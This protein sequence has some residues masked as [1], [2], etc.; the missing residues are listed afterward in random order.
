MLGLLA[1]SAHAAPAAPPSPSGAPAP[2]PAP[3]RVPAQTP[4]PPPKASPTPTPTPTP[5]PKATPKPAPKATIPAKPKP[6]AA[7]GRTTD[8]PARRQISGGPSSE[9]VMLGPDTAELRA[10]HAAERELFPIALPAAGGA[11]LPYPL[12]AT[13]EAPR[14]HATGLPPVPVSGPPPGSEGGRDLS[15]LGKLELPDVPVRWDARL[16]RYLEFFKDDPRGRAMLSVWLRRS[17]RYKDQLKKVLRRK[18]VPE[19]LVWLAMIESGFEPTARSPVGA[20]GIWQFMPDTGRAYGLPQDRWADQRL[21]VTQ[22]TEAAAD[23]LGD[24]HRRFGSW[25]LAIAA[26]NM[27]YGGI[28]SVVRRYNTNDFWTL[29]RLEGALPWETTLYVPKILAAAIVAKNPAVFGFAELVPDAP[30]EADEVSVPAGVALSVV[31]SAA[32]CTVKEVEA[33][34]PELRASRTPPPPP[35]A[36][37]PPPASGTTASPTP[38]ADYAV[39]V[40][41]GKGAACTA[42][43]AKSKKDV[44][45]KYVVRFGETLEQIAKD[46]HVTTQK[47]VELNGVAQNEIVRGGATLLVPKVDPPKPAPGAPAPKTPEAGALAATLAQLP[48]APIPANGALVVT[49]P[50]DVF[51]YPD[52]RR[53][54]YR[55]VGGDTLPQIAGAFHVSVD[56]LRRWNEL[57]PAARLLEGMTLQ[58]FVREDADLSQAVHLESQDVRVVAVGSE[59]FFAYHEGL[60][61]KKRITVAAK[62]GETLEAIGRKHGVSPGM[63]ERINH[64]PRA[65]ALKDG[66]TVA[67]YVAQNGPAGSSSSSGPFVATLPSASNAPLPSGPLPS[68]PLPDLLPRVVP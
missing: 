53:V 57:D 51:V 28:L 23:F 20:L 39:R 61:G 60:K 50:T 5:T 44:L 66:D 42:S 13:S 54:F 58:L 26:Y 1:G 48:S 55:V 36:P 17:G 35:Q 43:L 68:G 9:D 3:T 8:T 22:A 2:A 65:Q 21:N 15:W 27:G 64:R 30:V 19:D 38:A 11:E 31:A 34:N 29:S 37:Q 40:P 62:K 10:L 49:V 25:D 47:L 16:V 59:E 6:A 4:P 52:R 63:M 7:K 24:L 12:A 32:G 46:R 41:S 33:L 67:L 45:E 18:G 14:V 56:E